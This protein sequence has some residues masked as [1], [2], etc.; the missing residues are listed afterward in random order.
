MASDLQTR[1]R[2]AWFKTT[3]KHPNLKDEYGEDGWEVWQAH[4]GKMS[5]EALGRL[6]GVSMRQS[7][8]YHK[9]YRELVSETR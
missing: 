5:Q 6:I 3:L 8:D 1:I 4:Y 9:E 7:N 2:V